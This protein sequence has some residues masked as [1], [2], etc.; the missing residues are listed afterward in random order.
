MSVQKCSNCGKPMGCS[1]Q[2]RVTADG[3]Q[4]C[5]SCINQ[6]NANIPP[7]QSAVAKTS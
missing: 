7:D 5:T 2:K 6:L 3:R 4:G 1:C